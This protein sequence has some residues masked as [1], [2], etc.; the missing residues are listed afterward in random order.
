MDIHILSIVEANVE[1]RAAQT[2]RKKETFSSH[3]TSTQDLFSQQ[4]CVLVKDSFNCK[5]L[6]PSHHN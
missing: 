1:E 4:T 3:H 5:V 6:Y 2:F